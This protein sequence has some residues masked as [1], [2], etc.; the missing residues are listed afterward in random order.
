LRIAKGLVIGWQLTRLTLCEHMTFAVIKAGERRNP[1]LTDIAVRQ[2]RR[3]ADAPS[4]DE[5]ADVRPR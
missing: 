1:Q 3:P 5:V 2:I 4:Q